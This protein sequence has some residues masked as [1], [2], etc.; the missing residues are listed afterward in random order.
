MKQWYFPIRRVVQED[1]HGCGIA[2]VA[3]VCGTTYERAR[4]EFFPRRRRFHDDRSLHVSMLQMLRA[5]RRLG[6][7]AVLA[8]SFKQS[9][10]PAIAFF[11]WVPEAMPDGNVHAVVWDPFN[12]QLIDV[13][14]DHDRGL[15]DRFYLDLW[16]RSNFK[17]IV[18]T[19]RRYT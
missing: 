1:D 6:F 2:A 16:K 5:V 11:S 8:D 12:K 7:S 17:S 15:S 18:V 10:R 13:G 19:G 14:Y 3:T 4:S 9:K